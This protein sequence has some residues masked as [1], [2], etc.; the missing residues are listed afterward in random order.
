L[1]ADSSPSGRHLESLESLEDIVDVRLSH[2]KGYHF[3]DSLYIV[4]ITL[5]GDISCTESDERVTRFHDLPVA[6]HLLAKA[7]TVDLLPTD[8]SGEPHFRV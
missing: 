1:S 4:V 5:E 8:C 6:I 2:S 7:R 3:A